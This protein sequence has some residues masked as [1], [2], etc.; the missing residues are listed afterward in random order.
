M[1]FLLAWMLMAS[2][3][4]AATMSPGPAFVMTVRSSMTY[5]R[6]FG[7]ATAFGLAIGV[8]AHVMF[9]LLGV[10]FIIAQSVFLYNFIRYAGAAYLFY[11]GV[12]SILSA[13]KNKKI[14]TV[15]DVNE[16]AK[17]KKETS[18]PKSILSG[19]LT[20]LLN[21]KAVIYFTAVYTQFI[22]LETPVT[23]HLIYGATSVSIEFLW[24]MGLSIVLTHR[25]IRERFVA[26][27]QWVERICGGL[28]IGLGVKLALSK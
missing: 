5:G 4:L 2:V 17:P 9:V 27:M 12:K 20:N 21:P 24:F 3:S 16:S 13:R 18:I 11:I 15:P 8:M 23:T 25:A 28:M 26:C 7:I 1:E 19:F 10:S 6:A 22:T 14:I